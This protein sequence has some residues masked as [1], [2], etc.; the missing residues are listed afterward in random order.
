M[1]R[2]PTC[3]TLAR[4]GAKFCTTCGFRFP[5][6]ATGG[7]PGSNQMDTT[8]SDTEDE[9]GLFPGAMTDGWP[10]PPS[11]PEVVHGGWGETAEQPAP[12]SATP[13]ETVE[14]E[15]ASASWTT[16]AVDSWPGRPETAPTGTPQVESEPVVDATSDPLVGG[17]SSAAAADEAQ[18]ADAAARAMRLLEELRATITEIGPH[19]AVDLSGVIS[20][21]EVAVNPPGAMAA[22]DVA[23][24]RDALIAARERPRDVD[25]ILDL[26]TRIDAMLAL[27][28]AYDRTVAAIERSLAALRG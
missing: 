27:V 6:G 5:G 18:T 24:L 7:E 21:L 16:G 28:I 20:E 11:Q 12:E 9:P 17:D 2:C 13:G 1:E 4:P 14:V 23:E 26:T 15:A 10:A 25:T 3:G 19:G 8:T 22:D